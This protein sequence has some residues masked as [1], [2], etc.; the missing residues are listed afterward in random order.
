MI[1]AEHGGEISA[2][3][4]RAFWTYPAATSRP[5]RSESLCIR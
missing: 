3:Q 4:V 5:A 1:D 2:G